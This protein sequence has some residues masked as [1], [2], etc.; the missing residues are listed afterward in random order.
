M[1]VSL[2]GL[3]RGESLTS[4][5]SEQLFGELL[6]GEMDPI[7][8][9]SLLTALKVK[10]ESPS[11]IV[12]AAKALIAAA[13]P[14]PRPDYEFCDIVGTGGD[15]LHTI[16][17]STT[18]ALVGATCVLRSLNTATAVCHQKPAHPIC[19]INSASSWI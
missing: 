13:K 15:G 14:F 18:A 3:Y 19:W 4:I 9:S 2:E 12:G 17:I 7:V 1:T 11:E 5:E 10:G 16:N 8:L 6:R